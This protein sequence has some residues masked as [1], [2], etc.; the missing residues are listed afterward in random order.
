MYFPA[1][2]AGTS[3]GLPEAH[4]YAYVF[5][6]FLSLMD[7]LKAGAPENLAVALHTL[8]AVQAGDARLAMLAAAL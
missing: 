8:H 1:S 4:G 3:E 6:V 5:A 2:A 7:A